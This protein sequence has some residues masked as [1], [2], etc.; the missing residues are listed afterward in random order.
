MLSLPENYAGNDGYHWSPKAHQPASKMSINYE[1]QCVS[2]MCVM[3]LV[4]VRSRQDRQTDTEKYWGNIR[5]SHR[6]YKRLI[7]RTRHG[8]QPEH[9]VLIY[10]EITW[11][12]C[13]KLNTA[14]HFWGSSLSC[15]ACI[16]P[17][18]FQSLPW[19][20]LYPPKKSTKSVS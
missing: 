3:Y 18:T 19:A 7:K 9:L 14:R 10:L 8:L 1:I 5:D 11:I 4:F 6:H 2:Q 13:E 17:L 15:L 20:S 16:F 12:G